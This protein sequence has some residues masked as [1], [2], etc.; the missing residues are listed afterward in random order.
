MARAGAAELIEQKDLTGAVIAERLLAL[1]G[2]TARRDAMATAARKLG[3]PDAARVI[4][5]RVLRL[6]AASPD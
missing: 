2:D 6:A 3:R 4:V 5:D 1:A